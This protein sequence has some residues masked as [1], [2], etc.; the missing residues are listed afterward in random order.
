MSDPTPRL[1]ELLDAL[2]GVPLDAADRA[3]LADL[4]RRDGSLAEFVAVLIR[5][6]R[7]VTAIGDVR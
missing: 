4:A 7:A 5:R 3:I 1:A 2:N 6:V